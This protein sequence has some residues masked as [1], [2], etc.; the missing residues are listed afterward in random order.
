MVRGVD[1]VPLFGSEPS[2][3]SGEAMIFAGLATAVVGIVAAVRLGG[4][5][6][7]LL[8][9]LLA[10]PA[11]LAIGFVLFVLQVPHL[12]AWAENVVLFSMIG[13]I[14]GVAVPPTRTLWAAP[15]LGGMVVAGLFGDVPIPGL[16]IATVLFAIG[17]GVVAAVDPAPAS[18]VP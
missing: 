8:R 10:V 7:R 14:G 2:D 13:V 16:P 12:G 11:G 9:S 4:G 17:V 5:D 1:R 3:G 18:V 6:H 15:L